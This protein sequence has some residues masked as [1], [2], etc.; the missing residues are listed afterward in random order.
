MFTEA[1]PM[2]S[3][4]VADWDPDLDSTAARDA[5]DRADEVLWGA[6]TYVG[7]SRDRPR[8]PAAPSALS[9]GTVDGTVDPGVDVPAADASPVAA[10]VDADRGNRGLLA[11]SGSM[12]VA[13]LTSRVTGFVRS[14]LLVAALGIGPVGNAYNSGN[15]LPNMIYELLLGG[16]LSSVLIPLLVHA[17]A[18]DDDDGVAYTQ[19]LLSIA[20]AGLA[21]MTLVA[22]LAAPLIAAAFAPAGPQRQLTSIFATLLLPEIFFYGLG[23]MF[24]AVLN[25]RHVYKPGAWSPVLN[26][27]IMIATVA[28]FFAMPGPGTLNPRTMTTPQVLVIGL[29]TTLGIAAQALV[30]I[31]SLR[32]S[33]FSW[34]WRF[35]A[36]PN[37]IGR[38]REVGSL[39]GWVL[40][41]VVVS[42]I[43]VTV[44][45]KVGNDN[46]GFSVF[47]YADLLFQM[48]FG[49]LVVSLLTAIMPRLSRAAVRGD[50]EAVIADMALAA[51]LSA[52]ALLP[53]TALLIALGPAMTVTL[54]A[55]GNASIANAHLIGSALAWSAFGL[56]PFALVMVQLRVFY[57]MRDGR[58]PTLINAFMVG[59][60]VIL[61][62][63]TNEAYRVPHGIS[64]AAIEWLN[65]ATSMSYVVGAIVGHL[66]LTRRLG[67]L[68]FRAVLRTVVQ[69]GIAA[70]VGGLVAY[71]CVLGARHELG[72][73][74]FGS[75]AGLVVGGLLGLAVMGAVAW[76]MR[77]PDVR[78]LTSS[79]RRRSTG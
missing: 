62:L 15:N 49:I 8:T 11:A 55:Y 36:R 17:Q 33:G 75:W 60:K 35:R 66:V 73:A 4:L 3:V 74:R 58:T 57:A 72:G 27:V 51:R 5:Q 18:S 43:G 26:N 56:F 45:Q 14:I 77:I 40:G 39:A 12:A 76:Q 48:P 68:G 23:A 47:T 10:P 13:S 24:I 71:A 6:T 61:I 50:N 78:Q 1:D 31:P 54:F 7:R 19:R 64:M 46:G 25:I 32:R 63:V 37:E 42:Q 44:I 65:I 59:T 79:A 22:V 16:V 53:V 38:M 29:G 21:L 30:L 67:R 9:A 69:V 70:A 20:T 34:Q 2:G 28:V 52:V 41:Y